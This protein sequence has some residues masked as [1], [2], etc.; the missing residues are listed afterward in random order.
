MS[1]TQALLTG[2]IATQQIRQAQQQRQVFEFNAKLNRQKAELAKTAG[3]IRR[4]R[5]RRQKASFTK[6]QA[7]AFAGAGVRLTGSPLQVIADSAAEFE[8]EIMIE[9]FNTRIAILNAQTSAELDLIRGS[10]AETL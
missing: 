8:D 3:D 9:D 10:Q 4:D 7:A 2:F 6:T 1:F 5:L